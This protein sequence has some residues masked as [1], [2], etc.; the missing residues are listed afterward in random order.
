MYIAA[1]H[2]DSPLSRAEREVVAVVVSRLNGCRYCLSHHKA[3]LERLLD[4]ERQK[5]IDDLATGRI[6]RLTDRESALVSFATKLTT[7][8][9]GMDHRDVQRLREVGLSDRAVLDLTQVVA[10]F[11]YVNRVVQGLGVEVESDGHPLGQWPGEGTEGQR[12]KGT[13]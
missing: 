4:P 7:N 3:G 13:G 12:D 10:Y 5:T 2:R 1:M 6:A 8:P 9:H 11:N